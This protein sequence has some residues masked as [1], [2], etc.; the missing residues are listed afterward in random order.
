M[1]PTGLCYPMRDPYLLQEVD[2]LAQ[3]MSPY[4]GNL[5]FFNFLLLLLR[6]YLVFGGLCYPMR[7][8]YLGKKLMGWQKG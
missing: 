2:E 5:R 1:L 4:T 7:D 6:S 3:G 8:P